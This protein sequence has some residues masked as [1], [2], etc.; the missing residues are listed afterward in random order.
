VDFIDPRGAAHLQSVRVLING[1][2][3]GSRA[4]YVYYVRQ[5]NAFLLVGDAGHH[6]TALAAGAGGSVQNGQCRLDGLGSSVS[7]TTDR[8]SVRLNLTFFPGFYGEKQIFLASDDVEGK[9]T[10]LESS[11]S[12][13][14]P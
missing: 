1:M 10:A 4:C 8:L 5:R 11:G 3:D 13:T 9:S 2:V 14:V 7:E 12:W 6:S